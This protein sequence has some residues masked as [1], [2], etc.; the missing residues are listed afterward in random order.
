VPVDFTLRVDTSHT[1]YGANLQMLATS[2]RPCSYCFSYVRLD[3]EEVV[4][5]DAWDS[6]G[7]INLPVTIA[8][9]ST[10]TVRIEPYDSSVAIGVA[11]I[12]FVD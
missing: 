12:L 5:W 9:G 4:R 10:H 6:S 7:Y 11:V 2:D 3:G 8:L 1:V